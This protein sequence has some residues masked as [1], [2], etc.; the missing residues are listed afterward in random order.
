VTLRGVVLERRSRSA[1]EGDR[2]IQPVD[3]RADDIPGVLESRSEEGN[4]RPYRLRQQ[5][6]RSRGPSLN[7][8]W[9]VQSYRRH[10]TVTAASG[11]RVEASPA[12]GVAMGWWLSG[13]VLAMILRHRAARIG[14]AATARSVH[15]PSSRGEGRGSKRG[16][17]RERKLVIAQKAA[18]AH[19]RSG[20]SKACPC[21]GSEV[22]DIGG[23]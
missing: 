9:P 14:K 7:V 11:S 10:P 4:P 20:R 12:S 15:G 1:H 23:R 17:R 2:S 8:A 6:M 21:V 13:F 22:A 18:R 16:A 19:T 5:A 3:R